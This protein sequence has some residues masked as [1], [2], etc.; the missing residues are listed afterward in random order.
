[1]INYFRVYM[2]LYS[3][4]CIH[5]PRAKKKPAR[6]RPCI[7]HEESDG[8][9]ERCVLGT[10]HQFLEILGRNMDQILV[11]AC[12]KVDIRLHE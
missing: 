4:A 10:G 6:S 1:M 5:K 9:A 7:L 8:L 11:I 2:F 12:F 3:S